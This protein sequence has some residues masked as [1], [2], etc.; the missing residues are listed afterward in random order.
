MLFKKTK[1]YLVSNKWLYFKCFDKTKQKGN[2]NYSQNHRVREGKEMM[3]F[4]CTF[5]SSRLFTQDTADLA[6]AGP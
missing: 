3:Q 2:S 6:P 4:C 5:F 1:I